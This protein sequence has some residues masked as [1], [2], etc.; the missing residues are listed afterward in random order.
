MFLF[1]HKSR[2]SKEKRVEAV[3]KRDLVRNIIRYMD[4]NVG[5]GWKK[6]MHHRDGYMD[7]NQPP[8]WARGISIPRWSSVRK[9]YDYA[10]RYGY[11]QN[12][13]D[14]LA[15]VDTPE[16]TEEPFA[17]IPD[18]SNQ[19]VHTIMAALEKSISSTPPPFN[20]NVPAPSSGRVGEGTST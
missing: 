12:L 9:L 16:R 7:E 15:S 2:L 19:K 18:G 14:V 13:E 4:K 20:E 1:G 5:P 8:A 3:Q 10:K 6:R 11:D 17:P